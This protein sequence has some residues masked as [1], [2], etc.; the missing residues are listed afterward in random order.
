VGVL[1]GALAAAVAVAAG[2]YWYLSHSDL[3][4]QM[5]RLN[6]EKAELKAQLDKLDEDAKRYDHV[7]TWV[8]GEVVW[9][10]ELYD[11]S[12]RLPQGNALRVT[13]VSGEALQHNAKIKQVAKMTV[14][15]VIGDN[16][17]PVD[18]LLNEM[19]K[20]GHYKPGPKTVSKNTTLQRQEYGQQF[21]ATAELEH[22]PPGKYTRRLAIR[23]DRPPAGGGF[24]FGDFGLFGGVP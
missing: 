23:D 13:S 2:G 6:K 19:A 10:D 20:D 9:L 17:K 12:D 18:D 22:V 7:R 1:L 8:D 4:R 11:L 24:G 3:D 15:G 21:V 5:A 14:K 16:T